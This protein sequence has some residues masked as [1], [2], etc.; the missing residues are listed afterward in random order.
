MRIY[1][2]DGISIISV[3]LSWNFSSVHNM[4]ETDIS[5]SLACNIAKRI[6]FEMNSICIDHECKHL[7]GFSFYIFIYFYREREK[8]RKNVCL[9]RMEHKKNRG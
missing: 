8:R 3:S 9:N 4:N 7:N 2:T 1:H 6:L 5:R